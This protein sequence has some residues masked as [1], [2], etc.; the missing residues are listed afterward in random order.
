[1]K[2][3][4]AKLANMRKPQEFMVSPMSDD[5]IMIQSDKSIGIFDYK[6]G[7]GRLCMKGC[8]FPH[9]ALAVPYTFTRE[10]VRECLAVCPAT[11]SV[12]R[13]VSGGTTIAY[14]D[15]TVQVI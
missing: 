9:L 10:F 4:N 14:I 15:N 11:D 13:V 5:R 2:Y 7:E 1:M 6:T 12:T 3:V 8:Y